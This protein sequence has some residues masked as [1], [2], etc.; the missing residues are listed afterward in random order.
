MKQQHAGRHVIHDT[1]SWFQANK[2]SFS[3]LN[4]G[5]LVKKQQIPIYSPCFDWGSNSR[6]TALEG[7]TLTITQLMQFNV[8][9]SN[10]HSRG[11]I[12]HIW[13]VDI[14]HKFHF[15]K[16]SQYLVDILKENI[17]SI[18]NSLHHMMPTD[19][20]GA[21]LW[22]YIITHITPYNK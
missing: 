15:V 9:D 17:K 4:V 19:F 12:R 20:N 11:N 16:C 3:L 7:S 6:S 22:K 5:C 10:L 8:K 14:W 1:L 2:P 18:Y 21:E 13:D